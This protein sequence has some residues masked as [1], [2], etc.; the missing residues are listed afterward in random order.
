M[1][2]Y[3]ESKER[4]KDIIEQLSISPDEDAGRKKAKRSHN[5]RRKGTGSELACYFSSMSSADKKKI[6]EEFAR[7]EKKVIITP[8]ATGGA[9]RGANTIIHCSVPQSYESLLQGSTVE[10]MP[11]IYI[12]MDEVPVSDILFFRDVHMHCMIH[13][14]TSLHRKQPVVAVTLMFPNVTS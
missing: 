13:T 10:G 9:L 6:R 1:I 3:C 11:H 4:G 7:G 14:R 8:L 12:S 5:K 2:L